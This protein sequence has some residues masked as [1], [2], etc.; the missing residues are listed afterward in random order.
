[1]TAENVQAL[2]KA[3]TARLDE[4]RDLH[5]D[6]W[7]A[8]REQPAVE[9][10][11]VRVWACS[12]FV[13][14]SCLRDPSLLQALIGN[15]HLLEAC[16]DEWIAADLQAWNC[17]ESEAQWMEAL[18]KFRRRHMVRIAWRDIAGWA[19]I[20]ETLRD[21]SALAD[22][23][24]GFAYRK[25]YEL[26]GARY[27]FPIGE[28]DGARQP[29]M[30]LGMGKLGARELNY[31]SD[32]D[33][34]FLYPEEGQTDG[35]RSIDN[36]EFFLRL[37]QK[38]TQLLSSQTVD[39]FVYRVDLRLRPFGDSGRVA[40]GFGAFEHYLQQ[41]GRDWERYAYVK[42]RA[43]TATEHF[44]SLYEEVL[45]PFVFRRY[46]D[47]GVF[48]SLRD[49]KAM[50]AREV[51]RRELSD[52]VKL[53]PG[54]IREIEFI[55]QAFQL[56]R[57]G[58]D[59]RLQNREL[60]TVLP[61]LASQRL[62]G[63]DAVADLQ[64]A[65][66][67]LRLVE[68]RLQEWNDEQTHQLPSEETARQR[69]A[70]SLDRADWS[71]VA[72]EL[73]MH[74]ERVSHW[75]AQT[76]F[77]PVAGTPDQRP[78]SSAALD[79]DAEPDDF[80][81]ALR[82]FDIDEALF[83]P[84]E[85][86]RASSY[87][88]RLDETGRR[89]LRDALPR[90]LNSVAATREPVLTFGRIARI[91]EMIGGRTVYLA[92][93]NENTPALQR[94]VRLCSQSQFLADQIA[95]HPLLLDELIDERLV[96]EPPTRAQ[97]VG[98]MESRRGALYGEDAER[99]VELLRHF[100]RAALFRV[101][102]ADLTGRLPLMKVSDR[103]T[104]IAELIVAEALSLAWAQLTAKHGR[105]IYEDATG[106]SRTASLIVVAYGKL[107]GLELGYSSDLDLVFLHDSVGEVQRTDGASSIEN[108]VF[109]QRLAQRLIHLLTVHTSAGRLY[110]VDTRLRPGGNRGLLAQTLQSFREYE[111]QEAWTW[112]HQ[113]LLRAR[114]IV[115]EP[116][117][118][119]AFESAR[120]EVLRNAV[121]RGDLRNEVRNMRAKMRENLSK[122]QPGEFD[123]KQD[124]GGI[125]DLEF[126]V[127]YWMLKWADK[128][129]E[130]VIFSDNIRQ[131][132]S[133]ASGNLV[134]QSRVDFLVNTY[135]RYRERLHRLSLNGA[136]NIVDASE[137][138]EERR[139]V[140]AIW[141]E[142]MGEG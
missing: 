70:L 72:T 31:S 100:Q 95:A 39:G 106:T 107:G 76:V 128:Y 104:D 79:L 44:P 35:A 81:K 21:L 42:A 3:A 91:L 73:G 86:L 124:A 26:L 66:R 126:L 101:A 141:D 129:P 111:F 63:R 13:A 4:A 58:G 142:V 94:L 109:F 47:F 96:E 132:E 51:E 83:E 105:P 78:E 49:M 34:V 24:I 9:E 131:L 89:R 87:Y 41:H 43:I 102:V 27:G 17:G 134:P 23:C 62:L 14:T 5:A 2:L 22:A 68:N 55:V 67:F 98:D 16:D 103:L 97:F 121:R 110:E 64:A 139:G 37:S 80:A 125:A 56:I 138:V 118:R 38:I 92:L 82:Q 133:L 123:L 61:L 1:M 93:L 135:R 15:G 19:D 69:L 137:F 45:R 25:N 50:I 114:A 85:Q 8:I 99:Q 7:T 53:G 40:L 30:I 60:Q 6:E 18:R 52:N 117:L 11:L 119:E 20:A 127:Q 120:V 54:G 84:L 36:T 90:I 10:S 46:L 28:S 77:G 48:E 116:A 74:R 108:T 122:A 136:K 32:I 57:G 88:R 33:L 113:S 130:I 112:E 71:S 29:M 12:E 140:V 59:R 115:G 75:F 65:Y